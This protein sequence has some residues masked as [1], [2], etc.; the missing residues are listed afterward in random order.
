MSPS[1]VSW[2]ETPLAHHQL[3]APLTLIC[4]TLNPFPPT[5]A[6][7]M[8]GSTVVPVN[9][10]RHTISVKSAMWPVYSTTCWPTSKAGNTVSD[11]WLVIYFYKSSWLE[12]CMASSNIIYEF[13]IRFRVST[14]WHYTNW[15]QNTKYTSLLS[16]VFY[17][18]GLIPL[19]W[20]VT[21]KRPSK[22]LCLGR[23]LKRHQLRWR[24]LRAAGNSRWARAN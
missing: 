13:L 6:F 16:A 7:S 11:I 14:C 20:Q 5:Q 3:S 19:K 22:T 4:F 12:C 9:R 10:Y 8:C 15:F 18:S 23:K 1:L 17:R 21:R 2:N 24:A